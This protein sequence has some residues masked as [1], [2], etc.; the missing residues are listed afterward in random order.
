MVVATGLWPVHLTLVFIVARRP[1]GP[2]L[3]QPFSFD[4]LAGASPSVWQARI[5][6]VL[7]QDG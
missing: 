3:Q 5:P 6:P 7:Q 4:R 1:T 2:W